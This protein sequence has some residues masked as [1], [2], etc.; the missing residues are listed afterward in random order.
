GAEQPILLCYTSGTTGPPKGARLV[1][2]GLLVTFAREAA[3][4]LDVHQGETF[5]WITDMGWIVGPLL[6][7][8]ATSVGGT[9]F[10][11]DGFPAYPRPNRLWDMVDRH[12]IN[13]LGVGPSFIR[14]L[15]AAGSEFVRGHDLSSLRIVGVTG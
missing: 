15:L 11:Y 8:G 9:L 12:K 2:G 5:S 10:L 6:I 4:Y 3:Y 14:A 1:H 13:I 7:I